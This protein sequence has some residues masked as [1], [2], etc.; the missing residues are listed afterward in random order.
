MRCRTFSPYSG[1]PI[2]TRAT[3]IRGRVRDR[4]SVSRVL[5]HLQCRKAVPRCRIFALSPP[6]DGDIASSSQPSRAPMKPIVVPTH[7]VQDWQ[8]RLADPTKHWRTG[9]SARALAHAW[10]EATGL[11]PEIATLLAPVG[12]VE[13][14]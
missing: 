11:P 2:A 5:G 3:P 1:R 9:Y 12:K 14:L 8:E 13:L 6:R 4:A 7:G 10:E